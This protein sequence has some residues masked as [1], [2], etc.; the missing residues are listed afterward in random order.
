MPRNR[1]GAFKRIANP[2]LLTVGRKQQLVKT[3]DVIVADYNEMMSHEGWQYVPKFDPKKEK[4]EP[5]NKVVAQAPSVRNLPPA[6][7]LPSSLLEVSDMTRREMTVNPRGRDQQR[8][9][10]E[11]SS[12]DFS[13]M[14][15]NQTINLSNISN[16]SKEVDT[17]VVDKSIVKEEVVINLDK[18][19]E[20]KGMAPKEWF[21]F[22]KEKCHQ[23]LNE[24][25]IEHSQVPN[26]KWELIKFIK[27]VI[28]D[29][30]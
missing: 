10:I 25:H 8:A 3:G 17:R 28:K 6:T 14:L 29:L 21:N 30:N 7:N 26:E 19:R 2:I 12:I 23:I 20:L 16:Q 27:S 4:M 5:N 15:E 11:G 18:L 1:V 9:V 24:A 22:T 13:P